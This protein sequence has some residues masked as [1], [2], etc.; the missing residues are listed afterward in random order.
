MFRYIAFC[1]DVSSNTQNEFAVC[2]GRL[3]QELSDDW[4][5]SFSG[6][7]IRVFCAGA[8]STPNQTRVLSA[9]GGVVLGPLF[10]RRDP[11]T[12]GETSRTAILGDT[13][14]NLILSTCG[15]SLVSRYWGNYVAFLTDP[16]GQRK[17]IVKDPTGSLPCFMTAAKGVSIFFSCIADCVRI[18]VLRFSVNWQWVRSRV[19]AGLLGTDAPPLNE[20]SEVSRGECITLS[21]DRISREYYW[22][23][24]TVSNSAPLEDFSAAARQ[25]RVTSKACAHAW[26]EWYGA[27]VHRL[28]GGFD[29][30]TV[31]GCIGDAP[32]APTITCL[33]LY[34]P[35]G[36]SDERP[37]ARLAARRVGCRH[38]EHERNPKTDLRVMLSAIHTVAP[39][40]LTLYVESGPIER[41]LA[42]D[43]K[44]TAVLNGDG[45]DALFGRHARHFAASEYIGW[46]GL[47]PGLLRVSEIVALRTERTVW[48]VLGSAVWDRI[49]RPTMRREREN[50]VIGRKLVS[51]ELVDSILRSKQY[52][53]PWFR[54]INYV[55]WSLIVKLSTLLRTPS[56]Y[57]PFRDPACCDPEPLSPLC[58]Q[59]IVEL[60]LRIPTYVHLANGKDRGL[61]RTAFAG[62]LP[63]Q[64]VQRQWKDRAPRY[65]EEM[66]F[67][68]RTF[69]KEVI[70]DGI[71]VREGLLDKLKLIEAFSDHP[72][73]SAGY[74]SEILDHVCL[75][76]W[77]GKWR[78]LER[79]AA[80]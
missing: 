64:I 62:D 26:M 8:K 50:I 63:T 69:F 66:M 21:Q 80:A 46:H 6:S 4:C 73:K 57:D 14:S 37:W 25:L 53:H 12:E 42:R 34:S 9:R 44:A 1:W 72:T 31:L 48:N 40:I 52:P 3:V 70:S 49:F 77:L 32:K 24:L 74:A 67:W 27:V 51:A 45:G 35:S 56:F 23:P 28:S 19:A 17:W 60:C 47:T 16:R 5:L 71:L 39:E 68:N 29:S 78:G 11:N 79:P 54:S 75:E 55:P 76:A 43:S 65:F 15:R 59:P 13:E 38:V 10:E 61:A 41:L 22:H 58:S 2:L 7:G 36:H 33:T 18:S 20:V 30:S